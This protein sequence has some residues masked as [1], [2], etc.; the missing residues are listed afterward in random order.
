MLFDVGPEEDVFE[1]NATRLGAEL[2]NVEVIHLS[3]WHR[4]HS[5]M[6][7]LDHV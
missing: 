1:R 2:G 3:H 6:L 7:H 5:G 4:D